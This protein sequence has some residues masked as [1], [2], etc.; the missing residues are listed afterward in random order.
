MRAL[1]FAV[2]CGI[3][4]LGEQSSDIPFAYFYAPT[5]GANFSATAISTALGG[6]LDTDFLVILASD[7]RNG[8]SPGAISGYQRPSSGAFSALYYKE[9]G[10]AL[11]SFVSSKPNS[12]GVT[13]LFLRF[14]KPD[15]SAYSFIASTL[16]DNTGTQSASV[17]SAVGA[18]ELFFVRALNSVPDV[19]SRIGYD[20]AGTGFDFSVSQ[21]TGTSST[22]GVCNWTVSGRS[23]STISFN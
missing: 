9:S 3:T 16:N 22:T 18:T 23:L 1:D 5:A 12:S 7:V 6:V 17:A 21:K 2:F 13:A 15:N 10:V 4:A 14:R 20:N 8:E 19:G 11:A